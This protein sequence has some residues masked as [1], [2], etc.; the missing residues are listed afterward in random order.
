MGNELAQRGEE[1]VTERLIGM[2]WTI[3]ERNYRF[4][5]G[6][7]DIIAMDNGVTVFVEVKTRSSADYGAPE[8]SVTPSKQRQI[9]KVAKGYLYERQ[10]AECECR[11]DVVT[12]EFA[13]GNPRFNHI[14]N[15]FMAGS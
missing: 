9:V 8:Y 10:L 5:R 7:I 3:V 11:F 13:R 14:R 1:L 6:E 4:S 15:A 2:G 12:V